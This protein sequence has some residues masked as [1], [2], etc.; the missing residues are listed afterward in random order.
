MSLFNY[1]VAV[2]FPLFGTLK[3]LIRYSL[4]KVYRAV[5]E[6]ESL[7][8]EKDKENQSKY[9]F[10]YTKP[11]VLDMK[12]QNRDINVIEWAN[13]PKFPLLNED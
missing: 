8:L 4:S 7:T 5:V 3:E 9:F 12:W 1:L 2:V 10:N 13:I 11:P 6:K